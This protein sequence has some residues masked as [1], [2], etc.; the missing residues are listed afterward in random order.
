VAQLG[1][2]TSMSMTP[3]IEY[4]SDRIF[5][6]SLN[7]MCLYQRWYSSG[8]ISSLLVLYCT[9][10]TLKFYKTSLS[11]ICWET[12]VVQVLG[13]T[14]YIVVLSVVWDIFVVGRVVMKTTWILRPMC[15]SYCKCMLCNCRKPKQEAQLPQGN[16]ATHYVSKFVLC[17]TRYGS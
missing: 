2:K 12:V 5:N 6:N 3:A 1:I 14:L 11:T 15:I 8:A 9:C 10:I 13:P 7:I 4:L 16:R 17:F